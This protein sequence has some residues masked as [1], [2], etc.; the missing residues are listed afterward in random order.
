MACWAYCKSFGGVDKLALGF[1]VCA[2]STL[3]LGGVPL[4]WDMH[5]GG[6]GG[7]LTFLPESF[8]GK[9]VDAD[10]DVS[11]VLDLVVTFVELGRV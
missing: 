4:V 10:D 6:V 3:T 1:E 2:E 5:C 7:D 9:L 8:V 11:F